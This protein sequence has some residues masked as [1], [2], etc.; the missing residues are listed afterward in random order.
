L[1]SIIFT[2]SLSML[3]FVLVLCTYAC[4]YVYNSFIYKNEIILNMFCQC[5]VLFFK[6]MVSILV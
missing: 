6:V 2:I 5:F 1:L 4:V 3:V